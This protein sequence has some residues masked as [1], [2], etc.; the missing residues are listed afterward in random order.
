M[1]FQPWRLIKDWNPEAWAGATSKPYQKEIGKQ[2]ACE[3][4]Y[5]TFDKCLVGYPSTHPNQST[6][7]RGQITLKMKTTIC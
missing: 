3:K 5:N 4:N 2:P 7:C 1:S 6:F